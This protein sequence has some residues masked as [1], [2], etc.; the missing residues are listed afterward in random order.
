MHMKLGQP[1]F[2]GDLQERRRFRGAGVIDQ[3]VDL[4]EFPDH[5]GDQALGLVVIADI[6]GRGPGFAA[7][8]LN[9]G[10][11]RLGPFGIDIGDRHIGPCFG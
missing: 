6:G 1:A 3:Y 10:G 9:L 2:L 11:G 4:A 7:Q 5:A 8:H